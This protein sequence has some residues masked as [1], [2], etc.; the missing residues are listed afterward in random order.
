M[1]SRDR[2][3]AEQEDAERAQLG[4][5]ILTEECEAVDDFQRWFRK[6]VAKCYDPFEVASAIAAAMY[7]HLCLELD[8]LDVAPAI[9][10]LMADVWKAAR[11]YPIVD[12][13]KHGAVKGRK[14]RNGALALATPHA[15][16]DA[17]Y[18]S[19]YASC[20]D[21]AKDGAGDAIFEAANPPDGGRPLTT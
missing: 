5:R 14:H 1:S 4:R 7:H 8:P 13:M 16:A 11:G 21:T 9:D 2:I 12:V 3:K 20:L 18:E 17:D 19:W 6:Q 10:R 15:G